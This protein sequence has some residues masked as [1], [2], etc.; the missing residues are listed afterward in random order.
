M[1][2]P[3]SEDLRW[4]VIWFR[5]FGGHSEEETCFYL[6]ISKWTLWRYLQ[7][8][9]L[10]GNVDSQ[11]MGRPLD[12]VQF[13]PREELIIME[14]VLEK[15][16]VTLNEIFE[17]IYRSTGSEFALS[18][19]HYYLKRNGI[20]RKKVI[21]VPELDCLINYE[22]HASSAFSFLGLISFTKRFV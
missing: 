10:S 13:Q 14:A 4:R 7:S 15:P 1:P 12:S 20:T 3:Y 2:A 22:L 16:T 11:R 8:Y 17:E 5:L 19:I 21:N 6:G 9:L 18:S